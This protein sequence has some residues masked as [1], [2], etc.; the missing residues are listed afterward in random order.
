MSEPQ[1]DRPINVTAQE[2]AHPSI[3]ALARACIA[4]ARSVVAGAPATPEPPT[5]AASADAEEAQPGE[6]RND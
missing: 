6:R 5:S 1:S 3:T 4:L 2:R